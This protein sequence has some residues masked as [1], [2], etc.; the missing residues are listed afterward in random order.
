MIPISG[1]N[2]KGIEIINY[3]KPNQ[4]NWIYENKNI[5]TILLQIVLNI[6]FNNIHF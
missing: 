2:S 5:K 4:F 3:Y 1:F 6:T